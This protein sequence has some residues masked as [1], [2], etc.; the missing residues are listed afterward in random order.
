[1]KTLVRVLGCLAIYAPFVAV[2]IIIS[3]SIGPIHNQ[4]YCALFA[5]GLTTPPYILSLMFDSWF[6]NKYQPEL[7]IKIEI[8]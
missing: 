7:L 2:A 6:K 5:L 1:M 4:L 3:N 8:E